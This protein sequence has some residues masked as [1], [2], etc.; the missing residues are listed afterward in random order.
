MV[1]SVSVLLQRSARV[2]VS[3]H[4]GLLGSAVMRELQRQGYTDVLTIPRQALDLRD[5]K[6]T[7]DWFMQHKPEAVIHCAGLVGGIAENIAKPVEY[8]LENL[9]ISTNVIEAA[10]A[11]GVQHLLFAGSTAVYPKSAKQPIAEEAFQ[12]GPLEPTNATY[13]LS[14]I[15]GMEL[16][17]AYHREYGRRYFCAILT[18]LYGPGDKFDG[19]RAHVLPALVHRFHQA[20]IHDKRAVTV[21]GSGAARREL[22][23]SDDA[24]S[25]CLFLLER[26]DDVTPVN[27][28]LGE[29]LSIADLAAMIRDIVYREADI[30]FD[31]SKPDGIPQRLLDVS[32]I[33]NLG[34]THTTS[35]RE[36]IQ[37]T[38]DWYCATLAA[39]ERKKVTVIA[40][41]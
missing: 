20:K 11:C 40:G 33:Q 8:L 22:L 15:V 18:N 36:G 19:L 23:S 39:D 5:A 26:Y 35:L 30:V 34:W 17:N 6:S 41:Q 9:R 14:K 10:H 28:G 25:A 38:Y 1:H 3:G 13:A 16:C 21:W 37:K 4:T 31:P 27:V 12:Y 29:D 24:A 32:K 7:R 2:F